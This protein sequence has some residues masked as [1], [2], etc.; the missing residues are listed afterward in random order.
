MHYGR[1]GAKRALA[2]ILLVLI[3]AAT[4]ATPATAAPAAPAVQSTGAILVD[5]DTGQVLFSKNADTPLYPASTTKIMTALLALE[6]GKLEDGVTAGD[7]VLTVDGSRIYLE[8]GEQQTLNDLLYA[9][10]L[11][12]AND[13]AWAIAEHYGGTVDHFVELMNQ[14]AAELGATNT[15]FVNPNGLH[16]RGHITTARDLSLIARAAMV[17][18]VFAAIVS[19]RKHVMPWLSKNTVR[20]LYNINDMLYDYDGTIGVKTG[21]TTPAGHTLVSAVERDGMRLLSVTLHADL[22]HRFGDARNLM[23]WAFANFRK[24]TVVER[25]VSVGSLTVRTQRVPVVTVDSVTYDVNGDLPALEKEVVLD[26]LSGLPKRGQIVG[27]LEL[28]RDG[29]VITSV[30]VAAAADVKAVP[31][32][33]WYVAGGVS[34]TGLRVRQLVVRRRRKRLFVRRR[35]SCR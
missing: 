9:M 31:V 8:P 6:L 16:D 32:W 35:R 15:H 20:E 4:A 14:R 10:M 28:R 24:E 11:S 17:N 23:D 26:K 29:Q 12:S 18:P 2:A 5:L 33:A 1:R 21:F 7:D 27:R 25:G 3:V 13:A 22:A 30:P 19:T 34:M